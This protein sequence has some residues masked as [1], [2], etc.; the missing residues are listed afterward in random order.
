LYYVGLKEIKFFIRLIVSWY[1]LD[2]WQLWNTK[3]PRKAQKYVYD[4][5]QCDTQIRA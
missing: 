5:Y 1:R 4:N 3:M 2:V